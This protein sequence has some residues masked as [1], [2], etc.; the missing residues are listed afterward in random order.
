MVDSM[1]D[2]GKLPQDFRL[3]KATKQLILEMAVISEWVIEEIKN[4]MHD[5]IL[6]YVE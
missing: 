1:K 6:E 2:L 3:P 4:Q 5:L